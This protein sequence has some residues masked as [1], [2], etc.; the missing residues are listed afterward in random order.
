MK[1]R[2]YLNQHQKRLNMK[3]REI[4]D[5]AKPKDDKEF[6]KFLESQIDKIGKNSLKIEA[7][8]TKLNNFCV[9]SSRY[10]KFDG[11]KL[12]N[13]I[14]NLET[15]FHEMT[16][17]NKNLESLMMQSGLLIDEGKFSS[18]GSKSSARSDLKNLE[19]PLTKSIFKRMNGKQIAFNLFS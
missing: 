6:I 12:D 1:I 7:L 14:F 11:S 16:E 3:Q 5:D 15:K 8:E 10:D 19:H 18:R 4:R 17:K 9:K 13:K 2:S